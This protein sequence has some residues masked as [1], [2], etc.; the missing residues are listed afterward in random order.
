MWP[1]VVESLSSWGHERGQML[2]MSSG[3]FTVIQTKLLEP[4]LQSA[5]W[6]SWD[7]SSLTSLS[8]PSK[9]T[10]C[11]GYAASRLPCCYSP[12]SYSSFSSSPSSAPTTGIWC[13]DG[14]LVGAVWYRAFPQARASAL[15]CRIAL[16]LSCNQQPRIHIAQV[17]S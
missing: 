6:I 10:K 2:T 5:K 1:L 7:S 12:C 11:D 14:C 4:K 8:S 9:V 3:N 17:S 13:S 15:C 16:G